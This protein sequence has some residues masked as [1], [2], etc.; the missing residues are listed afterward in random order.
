MMTTTLSPHISIVSPVY[1]AEK[2][3]PELVRRIDESISKITTNYEIILVEDCGPDN[4]W[5]AIEAV[6]KKNPRVKGFK[7]SRNFGQHY[8]ITCGL[9]HAKGDWVVVMDCDLQD[10]P[11]EIYKLYQKTK[12]GYDVVLAQRIDRQDD[13]F[14]RF[15][16]KAFYR[17]LAYLTGSKMDESVANFG[18]YN[19]KVIQALT[20][21]RESIRYFPTMVK[22]VGFN[23]TAIPIEHAE[24]SEGK[25]SYNFK[26]LLNLALDIILAY[27]DK[28][29]RLMI[30]FGLIVSLVSFVMGLVFLIKYLIGEVMVQGYTSLVISI[31]FFS[32]L[33]LV[34]LGVVGLY[35]GKTFEGVKRRPI[36]IVEKSII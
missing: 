24:R 10:Q 8:A 25:S 21:M 35:V 32:G 33:I 9:D 2:I 27:S 34:M 17:T 11:E 22:W 36:Y 30:K 6:A 20:L 23:Q 12:E 19:Q 7:L 18:I 29:I 14:K 5:T 16:S 1:R 26:R 31:W 4:S 3:I 28:P 13:V 15:F